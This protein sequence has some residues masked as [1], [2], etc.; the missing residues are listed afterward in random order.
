ML[1]HFSL[2]VAIIICP[3]DCF[4]YMYIIVCTVKMKRIDRK[5]LYHYNAWFVYM[6]V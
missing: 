5:F 2:I 1:D 3:K 6:Y 4:C